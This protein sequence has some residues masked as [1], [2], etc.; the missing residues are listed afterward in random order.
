MG[1]NEILLNTMHC[2]NDLCDE[3]FYVDLEKENQPAFCPYCGQNYLS[4][5]D[6]L[7]A[8]SIRTRK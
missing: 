5:S 6:V 4:D 2:D 3:R 8:E 1:K 7:V